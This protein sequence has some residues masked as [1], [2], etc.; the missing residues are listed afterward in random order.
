M[1]CDVMMYDYELN[2]NRVNL[3]LVEKSIINNIDKKISI[4]SFAYISHSTN[5]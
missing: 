1:L 2:I 5:T 4:K 3:L